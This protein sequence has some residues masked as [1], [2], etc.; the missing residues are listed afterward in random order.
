MTT[1][2][3]LEEILGYNNGCF[4]L[5]DGDNQRMIHSV[6]GVEPN[7]DALDA[8]I[9]RE[10]IQQ[11]SEEDHWCLS[12]PLKM[13]TIH[14]VVSTIGEQRFN[15]NDYP[16]LDAISLLVGQA[17]TRVKQFESISAS[18]QQF[19]SIVEN[20]QDVIMLT[21][22]DGSI[23]YISPSSQ[24]NLHYESHKLVGRMWGELVHE[25]DLDIIT[26][27][28]QG[29]VDGTK[30]QI[31]E[32]RVLSST[33]DIRWISHSWTPIIVDDEVRKVVSAIND[34]TWRKKIESTLYT[35]L[36]ELERVNTDLNSFTH[37]VSHDLKAPLM[38]IESFSSFLLEDYFDQMDVT[39]REYVETIINA[40]NRM[41]ALIDNLLTLSRVGRIDTDYT[42]VDVSEVF[43]EVLLD[44]TPQIEMK[45][46]TVDAHDMPI[47]IT[48]RTWLKQIL[49]NLIGNGL[50]FNEAHRP[51]VN[52]SCET[53]ED[54]YT[55]R[56]RDN[57]IGIP[58][59]EFKHLFKLFQRLQHTKDYPGTGAG[60]SICKK[61]VES[62]GGSITVESEE[63]YGS[64]FI[65][66]I[67]RSSPSE[68][69]ISEG[70]IQQFEE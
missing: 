2:A 55:F 20:V 23:L 18:E 38:T 12:V 26:D 43:E 5:V 37:I 1:L 25:D 51:R 58:E 6:N 64:T 35:S 54:G 22:P 13:D 59:K 21:K 41:R 16:I 3:L 44:L 34:I 68:T 24:D 39:S 62:M 30:G 56:V 69:Q 31:K 4:T 67:P 7:K 52:V 49:Q 32:Y 19:R 15:K 47:I 48:Q 40:S 36:D 8:V 60:L 53:I 61:I 28:Y 57:G 17:I 70:V 63:G 46:A 14:G 66:S 65:F 50:K 11:T 29:S 9:E 45:H 10:E 33:G 42:Q 27:F